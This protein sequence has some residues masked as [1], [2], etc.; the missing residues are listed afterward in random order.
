MK[1][2]RDSSNSTEKFFWKDFKIS[3]PFWGIL[4]LKKI[5]K[6]SDFR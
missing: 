2:L 6:Q 1:I 5:F 4:E 3:L